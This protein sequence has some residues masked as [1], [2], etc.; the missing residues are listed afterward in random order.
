MHEISVSDAAAFT[1]VNRDKKLVLEA[2]DPYRSTAAAYRNARTVLIKSEVQLRVEGKIGRSRRVRIPT[3][4]GGERACV[5]ATVKVSCEYPDAATASIA[6][7][8]Q[9]IIAPHSDA[10]SPAIERTTVSV[11][12]FVG[13]SLDSSPHS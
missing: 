7:R 10:R 2:T 13:S 4:K 12:S 1:R 11:R 8:T 6:D 3:T 5:R 9:A